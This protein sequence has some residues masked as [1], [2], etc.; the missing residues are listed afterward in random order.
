[1]DTREKLE[2]LKKKA[3]QNEQLR[4]RI[5]RTEHSEQ[6]LTEFVKISTEEGFPMTEMELIACGEESYAAM[7]RSTN[8]GGENSPLLE[9]ED[10]FYELF[11][12]DLK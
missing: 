7:R 8:G 4:L 3:L 12:A 5:L 1:M 10:D 6:P 9:W 2:Q 11:L